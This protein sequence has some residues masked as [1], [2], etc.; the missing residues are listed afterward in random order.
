VILP[1]VSLKPAMASPSALPARYE[2]V[3]PSS[4]CNTD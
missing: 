4:T 1:R 2:F 3:T